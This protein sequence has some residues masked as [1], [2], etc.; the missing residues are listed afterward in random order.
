M[1]CVV[2]TSFT[3][4]SHPL[5][6]AKPQTRFPARR[7]EPSVFCSCEKKYVEEQAKGAGGWGADVKLVCRTQK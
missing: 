4:A 6:A 5:F 3:P 1:F 7:L 2:H